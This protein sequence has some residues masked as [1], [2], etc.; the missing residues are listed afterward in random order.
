M[1]SAGG[2]AVTL[3]PADGPAVLLRLIDRYLHRRDS[4]FARWL[5]ARQEAE[6]AVRIEPD[7]LTSWD[8]SA[9]MNR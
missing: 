4:E 9:R 2:G 1:A 6:V 3:S 8:F 5:I 7:W